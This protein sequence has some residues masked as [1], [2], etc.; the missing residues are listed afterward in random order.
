M[1]G[2]RVPKGARQSLREHFKHLRETVEREIIS[3]FAR[4][5]EETVNDIRDRAAGHPNWTDRTGNLRSSVGY[6][7]FHNGEE[8][9]LGGFDLT[10]NKGTN[11]SEGVE[12]GREYARARGVEVPQEG[13]LLIVSAGM[14]YA[15]YVE[16]KDYEVVM[17]VEAETRQRIQKR[18]DELPKVLSEAIDKFN[19]ELR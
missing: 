18:L 6:V 11:P 8:V 12:V 2:I 14:N 19:K 17:F 5:G 9:S 1:V 15:S 13:Y 4:A 10:H 16:K 3:A 7:V